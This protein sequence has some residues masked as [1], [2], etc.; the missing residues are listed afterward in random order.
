MTQNTLKQKAY[1]TVNTIAPN[2]TLRYTKGSVYEHCLYI[3]CFAN[4]MP[5]ACNS[6]I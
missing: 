6:W 3:N 2:Y 1:H 5:N 4:S